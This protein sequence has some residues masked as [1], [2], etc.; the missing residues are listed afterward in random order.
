[1]TT[2][3]RIDL[4]TC[5]Y[6]SALR[7]QRRLVAR[8]RADDTAAYLIL[9]E[10]DPP[11]IT[12]GRRSR[13]SDILASPQQLADSGAEVRR[14]GRGG[15]ATWHGPGQLVA[16][17]VLR[18]DRGRRSVHGH[19]RNLE[20]TVVRTLARFDLPGRRRD[21]DAGVWAGDAKIASVGVAVQRW[22]SFHGVAL[23]VCN[24]LSAFEMI[25]PC[26]RPG[27]AVTS[28]TEMLGRE[29]SVE[30]VADSFAEAFADICGFDEGPMLADG[31]V[32]A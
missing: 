27:A 25:V 18:L 4:P 8:V 19:V 3:I 10:H 12:L 11:V 30:D 26:G 15:R 20:E 2:L 9:T 17:P 22:V 31:E 6:D 5:D 7:L 24:D 21:G 13:W 32:D 23:N 1:M 16:Y 28:M 29:V 14:S